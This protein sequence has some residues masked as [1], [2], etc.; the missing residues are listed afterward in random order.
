[1]EQA[2]EAVGV[3]FTMRYIRNPYAMRYGKIELLEGVAP[4]GGHV[5]HAMKNGYYHVFQGRNESTT[6]DDEN[7]VHQLCAGNLQAWLESRSDLLVASTG[8][9]R[10]VNQMNEQISACSDKLSSCQCDRATKLIRSCQKKWKQ[11]RKSRTDYDR[12]DEMLQQYELLQEAQEQYFDEKCEP[13]V[14][15]FADFLAHTS[16]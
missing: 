9:I 15:N 8:G 16:G 12:A 7:A 3:A 13:T 10:L 11:S 6:I 2:L 4:S 5:F 14:L 1:M